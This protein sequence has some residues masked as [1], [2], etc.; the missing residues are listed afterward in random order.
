MFGQFF[1]LLLFFL[2]STFQRVVGLD[3]VVGGNVATSRRWRNLKGGP[4]PP[5]TT[6]PLFKEI[7]LALESFG[8]ILFLYSLLF[9]IDFFNEKRLG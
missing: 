5:P 8:S 9:L 3:D 2:Y 7:Y 1:L 4:P 6:S